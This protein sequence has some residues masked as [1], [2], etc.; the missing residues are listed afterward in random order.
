M[1]QITFNRPLSDEF[2][3]LLFALGAQSISSVSKQTII[4]C[5]HA[6][7]FKER[8]PKQ[9]CSIAALS[10]DD[11]KDKWTQGLQGYAVNEKIFIQPAG[12]AA[13]DQP[14][15]LI[16]DPRGAF[17]FNHPTTLLCL[18]DL[19]REIKGPDI[20]LLDA[21]TGSGILAILAHQMGVQTIDAFD[22]CPESVI[23][24]QHNLELN[25]CQI[26]VVQADIS[27]YQ[28]D[29]QYDIITANLLHNIIR[30]NIQAICRLLKPG[31]TLIA[32]G[33]IDQWHDELSACFKRAG[34]KIIRR[35]RLEGWNSYT[36]LD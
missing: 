32:S 13:S 34:L 31:G 8:L 10:D 33:I 21:G 26:K 12:E 35:S 15:N 4:T 27:G 24:A 20:S 19:Q 17:G 18:Q 3:E 22:L 23:R 25:G 9:I 6:E 30:D 2:E 29:K 1:Y 14:Y 5:D 7:L 11:W 36:L 16:I 28:S